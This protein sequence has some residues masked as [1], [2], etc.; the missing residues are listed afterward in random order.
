MGLALF[1]R[2]FILKFAETA[3]PLHKASET[4]LKFEW[5][6]VAQDAIDSLK[7]K[8]TSSPILAFRYRKE[9]FIVYT[10]ASHFSMGT[11]LAQVQDGRQ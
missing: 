4:S 11:V 3:R 5:T 10:D 8:L 1:Y 9:P 2:R 6:P 7:L